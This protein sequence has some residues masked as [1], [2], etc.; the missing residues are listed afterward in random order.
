[1]AEFCKQCSLD[2]F[3]ED[4]TEL[5]GLGGLAPTLLPGECYPALCEGCGFIG[6]NDYGECVAC[7]LH[8]GQPGHGPRR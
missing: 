5:A 1:M 8:A 3:G 6:V 2:L 7:H 4:H